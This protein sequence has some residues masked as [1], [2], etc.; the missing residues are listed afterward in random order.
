MRKIVGLAL[1]ALVLYVMYDNWTPMVKYV[2]GMYTV[3]VPIPASTPSPSPTPRVHLAGEDR[4]ISLWLKGGFGHGCPIS[5][6]EAW[7]AEHIA[8]VGDEG[9][10]QYA[11]FIIWGDPLGN[12]GTVQFIYGDKRRDLSRVKIAEGSPNFSAYFRVAKREP[13]LGDSVYIVGFKHA[14]GLGDKTIEA[15]VIGLQAGTLVYSDT[16]GPGSSGGC[17]LNSHSEVVAVNV[18]MVAGTGIGL[19]VVGDWQEIPE[20]F[21]FE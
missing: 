10:E 13:E 9:M 1:I 3:K 11:P 15:K 16:P 2:K 4:V 21:K 6:T 14:E 20:T 17:V 19:L 12:S 8:L 7:T 5:S 18:A